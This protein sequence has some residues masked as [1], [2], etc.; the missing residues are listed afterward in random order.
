MTQS[1]LSDSELINLVIARGLEGEFDETM[2]LHDFSDSEIS[3]EFY[4]RNLMIEEEIYYYN[5]DKDMFLL[6]ELMSAGKPY[7]AE[8]KEIVSRCTGRIL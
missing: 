1:T 6:Y 4:D 5:F 8:L 3:D 7:E 2:S